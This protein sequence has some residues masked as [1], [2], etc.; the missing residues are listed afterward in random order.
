MPGMQNGS[1][2]GAILIE[3]LGYAKISN[4]ELIF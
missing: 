1:Y 2:L 4:G 3:N